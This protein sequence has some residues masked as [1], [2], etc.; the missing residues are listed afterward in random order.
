MVRGCLFRLLVQLK[1][2]RSSIRVLFV[3]HV[4]IYSKPQPSVRV[5]VREVRERIRWVNV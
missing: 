4:I 1:K 5:D 2:L 3:Q